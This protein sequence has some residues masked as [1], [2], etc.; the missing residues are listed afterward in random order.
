MTQKETLREVVQ[1]LVT[2]LSSQRGSQS[3]ELANG[4]RLG[5]AVLSQDLSGAWVTIHR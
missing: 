1:R 5:T 3:L 4:L 2:E